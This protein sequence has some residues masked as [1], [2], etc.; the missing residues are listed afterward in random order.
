MKPILDKIFNVWGKIALTALILIIAALL[1]H[2]MFSVDSDFDSRLNLAMWIVNHLIGVIV[3]TTILIL[4][5]GSYLAI[6]FLW[7]WKRKG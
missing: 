1:S 5:W 4:G 2:I 3:W 7:T 6:A